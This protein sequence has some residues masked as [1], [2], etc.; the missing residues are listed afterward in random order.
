MAGSRASPTPPRRR[1]VLGFLLGPPHAATDSGHPELPRARCPVPYVPRC[2]PRPPPSSLPVI[3]SG[4][5]SLSPR[6][7]TRASVLTA[8]APRPSSPCAPTRARASPL[9]QPRP[10]LAAPLS[11]L[12]YRRARVRL[13]RSPPRTVAPLPP[14]MALPLLHRSSPPFAAPRAQLAGTPTP[15]P[16][17]RPVGCAPAGQRPFGAMP[18][19]THASMAFGPMTQGPTPLNV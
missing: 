18:V 16:A 14:T 1:P 9:T 10:L 19:S 6:A 13:R 8:P 4:P 17:S 7:R 11:S 12:T 2:E 5:R 15:A 3:G